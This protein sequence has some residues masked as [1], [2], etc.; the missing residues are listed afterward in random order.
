MPGS[1]DAGKGTGGTLDI[2]KELSA[3]AFADNSIT[4]VK[5][6]TH[7]STKITGL[8]AQTQTL[9]LNTQILQFVDAN[10]TIQNNAGNLFYDIATGQVHLWRINNVTEMQLSATALDLKSNALLT[11]GAVR[12]TDGTMRIPLSATPTMA[13]DGDFAIDTTVTDFSHGVLK[14]FDGEEVGIVAMPIAQFTSPTDGN[15]VSYNATNDEFELA[16]GGGGTV[17][18]I[19]STRL[20]FTSTSTPRTSSIFGE[21]LRTNDA[22]AQTILNSDITAVDNTIFLVTNSKT[23]TI[24]FALND[25]G[26]DVLQISTTSG[27]SGEFSASGSVVVAAGSSINFTEDGGTSVGQLDYSLTL[28]Y[29]Q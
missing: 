2:T 11:T 15:V 3:A 10:Q 8:P 28:E 19:F 26:V 22:G 6:A 12:I 4:D 21:V 25:D 16:A 9:D 17:K 18:Q 14:F 1:T 7:V 20:I 5:I 13:V 24:T 27:Q 29:T 23:S